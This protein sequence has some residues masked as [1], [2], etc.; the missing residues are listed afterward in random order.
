MTREEIEARIRDGFDAWN[1]HDADRVVALYA[2]GG[3]M[4]LPSGEEVRD[5]GA[6]RAAVQQYFDAF[7]DLKLEMLSLTIDG[8]RTAQEWRSRGTHEGEIAGIPPTHKTISVTGCAVDELD[9][10][11]KVKR[12]SNYYDAA[13]MMVQMG[14][15]PDPAAAHA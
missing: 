8:N 11:L 10:D 12:G 7:P 15:L 13:S 1:A 9:D 4:V 5:R 3:V 6:M 2:E 14:V